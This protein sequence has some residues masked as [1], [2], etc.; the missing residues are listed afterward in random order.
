M[1]FV[2]RVRTAYILA[3]AIAL[4]AT[5]CLQPA[6]RRPQVTSFASRGT[7]LSAVR[8]LYVTGSGDPSAGQVWKQIAA[9]ESGVQGCLGIAKERETADAVLEVSAA[10]VAG[11]SRTVSGVLSSPSG[12]EL[13]RGSAKQFA[14][15][16]AS[17]ETLGVAPFMRELARSLGCQADET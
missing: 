14:R 10:R 2:D 8:T 12:E 17:F 11:E 5:G 1:E 3:L 6:Y 4:F 13:W 9:G 7:A 16:A 15:G